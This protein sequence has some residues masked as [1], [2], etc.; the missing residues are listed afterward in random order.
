MKISRK[1]ASRILWYQSAGFLLLILLAWADKFHSSWSESV[2]VLGVWIVVFSFTKRLVSR[3]YYP[4]GFLRVCSW[5]RKIHR[6]DQWV[7]MEQYLSE[8]FDTTTSHSVCP[9]CFD[10]AKLDLGLQT[11]KK[12]V[13]QSVTSLEA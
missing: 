1:L 13:V 12:R 11:D 7:P 4:N 9:K 10:K 3:S 2:A 6:E 5:C 8:G